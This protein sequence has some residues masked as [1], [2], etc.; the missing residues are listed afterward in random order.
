MMW[1][2]NVIGCDTR[3]AYWGLDDGLVGHVGIAWILLW[4]GGETGL[5]SQDTSFLWCLAVIVHWSYP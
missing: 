3:R 5:A 2:W 1:V 4:K